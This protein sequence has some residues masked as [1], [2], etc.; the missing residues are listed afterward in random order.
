MLLNTTLQS[1]K[2]KLGLPILPRLASLHGET[3]EMLSL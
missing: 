2:Y 3:P 1:L